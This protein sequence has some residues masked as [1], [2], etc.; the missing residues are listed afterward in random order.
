M[1][2]YA[3]IRAVFDDLC[4]HVVFDQKLLQKVIQLE[5]GFVTCNQSH[6][7]FFNGHLTG[8]VRVVFMTNPDYN[9][10]FDDILETD[11]AQIESHLRTVGSIN[12]NHKVASNTFNIAAIW[13]CYKFMSSPHLSEKQRLEGAVR[14][15]Q[16]LQYKFLTSRLQR[17]FKYPASED[18]ARATY[19]AMSM[20]FGV[21][22]YGSWW[23]SLRNRA[24]KAVQREGIHEVMRNFLPDKAVLEAIADLQGRIRSILKKIYGLHKEVRATGESIVM[25]SSTVEIDGEVILREKTGGVRVYTDYVI[26]CMADKN[27]F[28]RPE[29]V[30]IVTNTMNTISPD[31]LEKSLQWVS[32]HCMDPEV[33]QLMHGIMEHVFKYF[34]A[35]HHLLMNKG[36]LP[37]LIGKLKNVYRGSRTDEPLLLDLRYRV[38]AM[39]AK[40]TGSKNQTAV[41]A[42]R[43]GF[44]LYVILRALTMHHYSS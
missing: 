30:E 11:E 3:N 2:Q 27:N 29:L 23:M 26:G 10:L 20:K 8:H 32:T 19:A 1:S 18:S 44:M 5:Q 17:H 34:E 43:T 22:K 16:Y 39:V 7:D 24:E 21:K 13:M 40:S 4:K 38:E 35:N 42:V 31:M 9:R 14:T 36:A 25:S 12:Y 41:C 15:C 37:L 6:M 33:V 28:I